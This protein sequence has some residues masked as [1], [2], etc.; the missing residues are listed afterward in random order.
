MYIKSFVLLFILIVSITLSGCTDTNATRPDLNFDYEF[1][2]VINYGDEAFT[3]SGKKVSERWEFSYITPAQI[4][5]MK[6]ILEN[7]NYKIDFNGLCQEGERSLMPE[8]CVCDFVARALEYITRGK[9]IEFSQKDDLICGIGVFD[10]GDLK[11]SYNKNRFP[12]EI[13]IG[14]DIKIKFSSFKKA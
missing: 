14:N 6:V 11:V 12:K 2:A 1:E 5:D 9:G 3:V 4:K 7:G 10:G 13:E 8:S